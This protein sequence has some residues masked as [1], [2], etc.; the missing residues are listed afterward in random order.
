MNGTGDIKTYS[1]L[2]NLAATV[3]IMYATQEIDENKLPWP[4]F[5]EKL[6]P[7]MVRQFIKTHEVFSDTYEEEIKRFAEEALEPVRRGRPGI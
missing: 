5:E 1:V 7:E 4:A 3:G 2:V 6:L